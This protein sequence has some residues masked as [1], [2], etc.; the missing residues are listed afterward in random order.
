MIAML[1]GMSVI[2]LGVGLLWTHDPIRRPGTIIAIVILSPVIGWFAMG[3]FIWCSIIV[4][5]IASYL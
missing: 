4:G 5:G 2:G 1:A 3:L